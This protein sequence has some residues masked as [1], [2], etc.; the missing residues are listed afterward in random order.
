MSEDNNNENKTNDEHVER[1]SMMLSPES[2]ILVYPG[3]YVPVHKLS[4][5][6]IQIWNGI[7]WSLSN[8]QM[9]TPTMRLIQITYSDGTITRYGLD[10]T[11]IALTK[12]LQE[13]KKTRKIS[14][15]DI[16]DALRVPAL[17]MSPNMTM[18][19][20]KMSQY[21]KRDVNHDDFKSGY[22]H[23]VYSTT[24]APLY[25]TLE[26]EQ[27]KALYIA[28]LE[29][30]RHGCYDRMVYEK[31]GNIINLKISFKYEYVP[32]DYDNLNFRSGWLSGLIDSR[33]I[34][35]KDGIIISN[36]KVNFLY[37]VKLLADSLGI[38]STLATSKLSYGFNP[39]IKNMHDGGEHNDMIVNSVSKYNLIFGWK[40]V[41]RLNKLFSSSVFNFS[42]LLKD[43]SLEDLD[44]AIACVE[45]SEA[46][47]SVYGVTE[48]E[49]KTNAC[50]VSGI[51]MSM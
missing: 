18:L 17:Y 5:K 33:S 12:N 40:S 6:K 31:E 39:N 9:V 25:T 21:A 7:E 42:D 23:G 11:G 26:N 3:I 50:R 16:K 30:E 22:T 47:D 27:K 14:S 44:V 29:K 28:Y 34:I 19:Q 45:Y 48:I 41:K 20:G 2:Y 38:A 13:A 10:Q 24:G 15:D 1:A 51:L 37:K 35:T 4:G 46:F 8:I 36:D 49:P 43:K 32:L